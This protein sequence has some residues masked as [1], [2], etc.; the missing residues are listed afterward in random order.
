M[1]MRDSEGN[2]I[3]PGKKKKKA[4]GYTRVSTEEQV[5]GLSL[6]SQKSQIA[7]YCRNNNIE[8]VGWYEELGVSAKTVVDRPKL[9]EMLYDCIQHKG[10]I[11]LIVVYDYTRL[12][13]DMESLYADILRPLRPLGIDTLSVTEP[14]DENHT[15]RT[16]KVMFGEQENK[17]KAKRV[18]DN[19]HF[20]IRQGWWVS[21]APLG[22]KLAYDDTEQRFQGKISRRRAMLIPDSANDISANIAYLFNRFVEGVTIAQ[23]VDEAKKLDIKTKRGNY[24]DAKT[25]NTLLRNPVYA[26]LCIGDGKRIKSLEKGEVVELRGKSIISREVFDMTQAILNTGKR[27][28]YKVSPDELYPL[29][30]S[31]VCHTCGKHMTGSAPTNGSKKSSPRY[32]CKTKGCKSISVG[33]AHD[34]FVQYLER[35]TPKEGTLKLYK[36]LIEKTLIKS[37][38]DAQRML[39][40]VEKR[41]KSIEAEYNKIFFAFVHD[42][43]DAGTKDRLIADNRERYNEVLV[44]EQKHRKALEQNQQSVEYIFNF[45][46]NPAKLWRDASVEERHIIQKII[47]PDG[48]YID[49]KAKKGGTDKLSP[50]YSVISNKKEH[51]GSNSSNMVFLVSSQWNDIWWDISRINN[52]LSV[53]TLKNYSPGHVRTSSKSGRDIP[54]SYTTTEIGRVETPVTLV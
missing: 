44:D 24:L 37:V 9:M 42:E 6:E 28:A 38:S 22:Y 32:H 53:S 7:D 39:A 20:A 34:I 2:I 36:K 18:R 52:L 5:E 30:G 35:I 27:E 25:L 16:L 19:M 1:G 33:Q 23:L 4:F 29:K 47:F 54:A 45:M 17:G 31:L 12:S 49:V 10:E 50:L 48:F 46:A 26:G 8:I 41:K 43:I 21:T 11:D 15:F 3:N 40:D 51:N 13:R 14:D